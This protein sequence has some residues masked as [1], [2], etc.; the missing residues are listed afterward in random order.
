MNPADPRTGVW[1]L[2]LRAFRAL[3]LGLALASGVGCARFPSYEAVRAALP[4]EQ[5]TLLDDQWV[6]FE[7]RGAGDPVVLIHGFG[8]S[9]YSWRETFPRLQESF[10]LLAVDLN[11]F[12]YT[13]RPRAAQDYSLAGQVELVLR[14]L[15][16]LHIDRAHFVGHSYGGGVVLSLARSHPQ[17]VQSLV[18]VDAAPPGG[19]APGQTWIRLFAPLVLWYTENF[20]LTPKAI[21]DALRSV[22]YVDAIVTSEMIDQYLRRLRIAGFR[23]AFYGLTAARNRSLTDEDLATLDRPALVI[24]GRHDSVVPLRTGQELSRKLPHATWVV[25]EQAGHLPMEEQPDAFAA[26]L[27]DFLAR[28][29][30]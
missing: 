7:R 14:L 12:G 27:R 2:R 15:D 20:A 11:G 28:V 17:R 10:D 3:A 9:T 21:G 25:I 19:A 29:P 23:D 30:R 16:H 24:W 6:H 5:L 8:G 18:L 26:A 22:V 13:Q 1:P 4:P